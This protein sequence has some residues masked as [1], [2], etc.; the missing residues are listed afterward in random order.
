MCQQGECYVNNTGSKLV[1]VSCVFLFQ[2]LL[3]ERLYPLVVWVTGC[4][5]NNG[6]YLLNVFLDL[7][8]FTENKQTDL[9]TTSTKHDLTQL[10]L[11]WTL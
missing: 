9:H 5:V 2:S 7:L 8:I 6:P 1:S 11:V 3:S 4:T 10:T